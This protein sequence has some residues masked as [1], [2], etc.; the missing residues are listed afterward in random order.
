MIIMCI[1]FRRQWETYNYTHIGIIL[2]LLLWL[3]LP[4]ILLYT[5]CIYISSIHCTRRRSAPTEE[6]TRKLSGW[7]ARSFY[8]WVRKSGSAE[9][10]T[11]VKRHRCNACRVTHDE[12]T[13]IIYRVIHCDRAPPPRRYELLLL[14]LFQNWFLPYRMLKAD[15]LI[16]FFVMICIHL[17]RTTYPTSGFRVIWI[18]ILL[19]IIFYTA[20]KYRIDTIPKIVIKLYY[21]LH[22]VSIILNLVPNH[23]LGRYCLQVIR[24]R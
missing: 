6:D 8:E 14:L 10:A 24:Y 12:H 13:H 5:H 9:A 21:K 17:N 20:L 3:L 23:L 22:Y 2:L 11:P 19:R 1:L 15:I 16:S 4:I 18:Y 7:P